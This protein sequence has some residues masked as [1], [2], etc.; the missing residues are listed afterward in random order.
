M[1]I[2]DEI[3]T[4]FQG[5]SSRTAVYPNKHTPSSSAM[6][7]PSV[8][9]TRGYILPRRDSRPMDEILRTVAAKTGSPHLANSRSALD[10]MTKSNF[11]KVVP[12][13]RNRRTPPPPP[14]RPPPPK[15]TK[16]QLELEE[17][18]E[19]ELEES[20]D[21]WFCLTDEERSQH[22][23]AKWNAERGYED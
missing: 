6:R 10:K 7:S 8:A 4:C 17:K 11:M 19:M 22:R 1:R 18:W 20:I 2:I 21:G 15:K 13:H 5:T 3:L 14:P 16:K 12:L 9:A 23:H